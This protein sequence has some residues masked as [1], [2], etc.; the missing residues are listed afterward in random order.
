VSASARHGHLLRAADLTARELAEALAL[1][2]TVKAAPA[3]LTDALRGEALVLIFALPSTRTRVAFTV[4]AHRLGMAAI[5]LGASE[6]Q[7]AR[8]E[9]LADTARALSAQ[10]S[11]VVVRASSH[12]LLEELAAAAT[13]P[14]INALSSRHHPCEALVSL[15]TLREH[16]GRL[17]GLRLAFVGAGNNVSHSL[18]EAAAAAGMNVRVACPQRYAPDEEVVARASQIAAA[19]EGSVAVG[20]D[21]REAVAGVD[22]VYTDVWSSMGDDS[23]T[24][25]RQRSFTEF[26]VDAALISLAA[27]QAVFLHCL[28]ARRGLE[29]TADVI[30]GPQS[31]VWRN[32]ANH[33]PVTQALV[34]SVLGKH[35]R[36]V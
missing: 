25:E 21:A 1:A 32:V 4:A 6:L 33:V 7:L 11:G 2:G 35:E 9:E 34:Y 36:E 28:P 13:V 3:T 19:T 16:F 10:A 14:V 26:R 22:V 23:E 12:E 30:D 17:S 24:E 5:A 15:F 20:H 29:V 27:P 18:L 8:G 31:L